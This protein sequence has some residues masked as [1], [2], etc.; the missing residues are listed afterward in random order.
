M[1]RNDWFV[2]YH[3]SE[4][5]NGLR[6]LDSRIQY[7]RQGDFM[8]ADVLDIGC[9]TGQMSKYALDQ[10]AKYVLGV[11]YDQTAIKKARALKETYG[12]QVDFIADDIDNYFFHANLPNFD[13]IMF[14][15]VIGTVELADNKAILARL[16]QKCKVMYLEGHHNSDFS[17]LQKMI[18]DYTSFNQIE[19]LGKTYDNPDDKIGRHFWRLAKT[20]VPYDNVANMIYDL[21]DKATSPLKIAVM[22][23][24]GVGKSTI[25]SRLVELCNNAQGFNQIYKNPKNENSVGY[26]GINSLGHSYLILD[27][28]YF[29]G[30]NNN[31]LVLFDYKAQDILN[32][33]DI[34]FYVGYNPEARFR[35]RGILGDVDCTL[36]RT[37]P[38]SNFEFKKLYMVQAY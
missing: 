33:A 25:R 15:S 29:N 1:K 4:S 22:G 13:T 10:G 8:G 11:D 31:S 17:S 6:H 12:Y 14:L 21:L 38:I 20:K 9:N 28:I 24:G 7:F 35:E 23:F 3:A 37:N 32:E 36:H 30:R 19:Y 27:D 2:D 34:V 5:Q 16:S 26:A 18:V